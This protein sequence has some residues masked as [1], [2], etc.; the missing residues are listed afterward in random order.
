[1]RSSY[2]YT[3]FQLSTV[4]LCCTQSDLGAVLFQHIDNSPPADR[5]AIYAWFVGAAALIVVCLTTLAASLVFCFCGEKLQL[6]WQRRRQSKCGVYQRVE[7]V[8]SLVDTMD[9]TENSVNDSTEYPDSV[10][11]I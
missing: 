10:T 7:S 4:P 3:Q 5:I 9:A 6:Y 11:M 2:D 1:M 8:S